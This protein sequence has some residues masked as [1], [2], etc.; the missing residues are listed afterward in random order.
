MPASKFRPAIFSR[1]LLVL[2]ALIALY[3]GYWFVRLAFAPVP[4]PPVPPQRGVIRF[5]P[6][7]D[8]SKNSLFF[9]LRP[10]GPLEV[11]PGQR[12]RI[13]PFIPTTFVT[14]TPLERSP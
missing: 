13:N 3:F 7:L 12:G 8:V 11:E 4:I 10:L 1:L 5:D 9:R 6:S 2:G 14:S